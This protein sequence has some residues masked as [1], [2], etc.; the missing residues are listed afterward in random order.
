[1]TTQNTTVAEAAA[2]PINRTSRKRNRTLVRFVPVLFAA[3]LIA[4]VFS[5]LWSAAN[6]TDGPAPRSLAGLSLTQVVAGPE[7]VSQ[8]SKLH[9]K[10]VG[11]VDGYVAHYQGAAGG[12][13]LYVGEM[14][15][16][17]NAV[18]LNRQMEERIAAGNPYFTDLKPLVVE[19]MQ[20]FSVRSGAE[21]H[22]FWQAGPLINWIGFDR[23]DP[24]AL[25]VA[26]ATVR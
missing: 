8:M 10:G 21:T 25:A 6:G 12:A 19:G 20:L 17:E 11:V 16:V 23:D 26:V 24:A 15:S 14:G 1:M 2:R 22:Y 13:V 9:G 4:A 5:G 7:A 3:V 18:A